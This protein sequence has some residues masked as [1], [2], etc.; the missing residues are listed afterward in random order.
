MVL[1]YALFKP[2]FWSQKK[3]ISENGKMLDI[4]Y[5]MVYNKNTMKDNELLTFVLEIIFERDK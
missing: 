3:K 2:Y 4:Y 1:I 5:N